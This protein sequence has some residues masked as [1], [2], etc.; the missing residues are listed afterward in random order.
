VPRR[1]ARSSAPQRQRRRR[2]ASG[3][4]RLSAA[5]GRALVPN[6]PPILMFSYQL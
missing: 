1:A 3:I 4:G 5:K 2:A 6:G